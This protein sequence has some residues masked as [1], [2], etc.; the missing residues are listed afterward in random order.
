L[1]DLIVT[2][3]PRI[4]EKITGSSLDLRLVVQNDIQQ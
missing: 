1:C 2:A 3:Q 4:D